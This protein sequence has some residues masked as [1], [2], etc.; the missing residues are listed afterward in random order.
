METVNNAVLKRAITFLLVKYKAVV[1][2]NPANQAAQFCDDEDWIQW[3]AHTFLLSVTSLVP[4]V[5]SGSIKIMA[6]TTCCSMYFEAR[7][8]LMGTPFGPTLI[9]HHRI[10]A[11]GWD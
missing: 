2:K 9:N 4:S 6:F 3:V 5:L 11:F 8:I 1:D 7:Y 10:S